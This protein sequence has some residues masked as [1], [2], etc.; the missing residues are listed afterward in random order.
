LTIHAATHSSSAELLLSITIDY[1]PLV[2]SAV[3]QYLHAVRLGR[4]ITIDHYRLLSL[5]VKNCRSITPRITSRHSYYYH[6]GLLS[7]DVKC[8]RSVSPRNTSW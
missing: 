5:D 7:I 3:D 8:R 1:Y 6:Y 4:A 2:P